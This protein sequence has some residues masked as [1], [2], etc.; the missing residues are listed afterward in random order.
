MKTRFLNLLDNFELLWKE[1]SIILIRTVVGPALPN[2][3]LL[4]PHTFSVKRKL[5]CRYESVLIYRAAAA[6]LEHEP[7]S[8]CFKLNPTLLKI[9]WFRKCWIPFL[10]AVNFCK[11]NSFSNCT[12]FQ[13]SWLRICGW[14]PIWQLKDVKLSISAFYAILEIF[15]NLLFL[16]SKCS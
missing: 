4:P 8:T 16:R 10:T 7:W 6:P 13:I 1:F 5:R 11:I 3:A 14:I 2:L 9:P 12:G 15:E